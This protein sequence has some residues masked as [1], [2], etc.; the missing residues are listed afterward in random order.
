M[1]AGDVAGGDLGQPA[2]EEEVTEAE[3]EFQVRYKSKSK[4]PASGF[5]IPA[6]AEGPLAEALDRIAEQTDGDL[7][8]F[9]RGKLNYAT[10][11][12][13]HAAYFGTQIDALAMAIHQ[14]A[15]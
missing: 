9:V 5:T 3:S 7:D 4:A 14:I 11:E 13:L 8:E 12:D 10:V 1:R 2:V 6:N 15:R